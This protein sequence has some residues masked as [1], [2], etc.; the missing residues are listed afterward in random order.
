MGRSYLGPPDNRIQQVLF[1]RREGDSG[2]RPHVT[3]Q[4]GRV[5]DG[6][7]LIDPTRYTVYPSSES[8]TITR[9]MARSG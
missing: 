4:L 1:A 5:L 8:N 3:N 6:I 2:T 7:T 9:Q